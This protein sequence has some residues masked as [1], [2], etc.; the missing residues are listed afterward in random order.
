MK[1]VVYYHPNAKING[2]SGDFD[3]QLLATEAILS[4]AFHAVSGMLSPSRPVHR[5]PRE[6]L[7]KIFALVGTG[8]EAVPLT[9]ACHRWR[10]IAL[11]TPKLW[12]SLS[13]RDLTSML[14]VF[15]E[16][17]Q[18]TPLDVTVSISSDDTHRL[19]RLT[20]L[21]VASSYFRSFEVTI[22]GSFTDGVKNA[23]SHFHKTAP[24]LTTL[25]IRFDHDARIPAPESREAGDAF[26]HLFDRE[27]PMLSSLPLKSLR[28][29]TPPLSGPLTTLTLALLFLS[30]NDLYICLEAVSNLRSLALL[31]VMST[32]SDDYMGNPDP[33]SL[34]RLDTL[35][36]HQPGGPFKHFVHLMTHLRFPRLDR[37]CI[38]MGECDT[39]DDDFTP[40]LTHPVLLSQHLTRLALQLDGEPAS[41]F[42]LHG[43]HSDTF[44]IS[45]CLPTAPRRRYSALGRRSPSGPSQSPRRARPCAFF[46]FFLNPL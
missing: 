15:I 13:D 22:L 44:V 41:K 12:T 34:D 19:E 18:G 43:A 11:C 31:N 3:A 20:D 30:A 7:A 17:S 10:H 29:W 38:L 37:A 6:T 2:S 33:I 42:Y 24:L 36:I 9:H 32:L 23:L 45:P 4:P 1:C 8:A 39:L 25:S 26:S 46:F 35:Y 5:V 28:P 16:R 14:P 40:T 21:Q 27:H